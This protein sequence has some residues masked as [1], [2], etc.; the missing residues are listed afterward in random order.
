[1][2]NLLLI[3]F[4]GVF[5]Y[6]CN[7]SSPS[8]NVAVEQY[9]GATSM[10]SVSMME[11]VISFE[12]GK[13]EKDSGEKIGIMTSSASIEIA[14]EILVDNVKFNIVTNNN[15][16]IT[17]METT[18]TNFVTPEGFRVGDLWGNI[19]Q[20][21]KDKVIKE[22]GWRYYLILDSGWRLGFCEGETCTEEELTKTTKI[23][24]IF[25]K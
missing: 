20:L 9:S 14:E 22:R 19:P 18:D 11:N 13:L 10:D 2:K 4:V 8:T 1:M 17:F 25:K 12:L 16:V 6:G 15:E 5:V 7:D 23:Q 21:L 3:L 24:W